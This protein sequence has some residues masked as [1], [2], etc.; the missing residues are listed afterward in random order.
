MRD[1]WRLTAHEA[2]EKL[3]AK[4]FSSVEL[5]QS[6]L[7][8]VEAVESQVRAYITVTPELA[9]QQAKEA[10]AKYASGTATPLTGIPV[11]VKDLIVTKGTR[12]TAGSKILENFIPPFDSHVYENLRKAG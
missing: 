10:D 4:E 6:V 1:L 9:L 3:R 11:A 12:T 2:H 7:D 8:R 5:T